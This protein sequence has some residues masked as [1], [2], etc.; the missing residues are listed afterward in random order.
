[1]WPHP[2]Y[3]LYLTR[4]LWSEGFWEDDRLKVYIYFSL[5][6][7]S[8]K[9]LSTSPYLVFKEQIYFYLSNQR[10]LEMGIDILKPCGESQ[11]WAE[12]FNMLSI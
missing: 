10:S 4:K 6:P 2:R 9:T 5:F 3:F 7:I 11:E 8:I 1:M 12:K